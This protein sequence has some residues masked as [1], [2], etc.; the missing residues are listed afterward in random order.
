M[1]LTLN[2][3][4]FKIDKSN[5]KAIIDGFTK[6]G[7]LIHQCIYCWAANSKFPKLIILKKSK[8]GY[9]LSNMGESLHSDEYRISNKY[10]VDKIEEVFI[11]NDMALW[12]ELCSNGL[13]DIW[14]AAEPYKFF[15][16]HPKASLVLL[17]VY[18][19]VGEVDGDDI[20]KPISIVTNL[21]KDIR[22]TIKKSVISD[23]E[24]QQVKDLF[25]TSVKDFARAG[26]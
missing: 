11:K 2:K 24:F 3:S 9:I 18:E 7:R 13:F 23:E 21:K 26:R 5:A 15:I 1:E 16:D 25:K 6:D 8:S 20:N 19:I 17:R 4:C 14:Q 12:N 22:V 10:V